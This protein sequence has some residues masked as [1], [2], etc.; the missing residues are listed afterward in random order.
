MGVVARTAAEMPGMQVR[1]AE[2]LLAA[3]LRCSSHPILSSP[4]LPYTQQ[5]NA[6]TPC[7]VISTLLSLHQLTGAD[8][9]KTPAD[10]DAAAGW[11]AR[12]GTA[13]GTTLSWRIRRDDLEPSM[14][15]IPAISTAM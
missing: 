7:I 6:T 2:I 1:A 4:A 12:L 5:P 11:E 13:G 15:R 8:D 14:E 10:W 9:Q 3:H